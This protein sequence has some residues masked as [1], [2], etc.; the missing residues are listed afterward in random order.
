MK[1]KEKFRLSFILF[2]LFISYGAAS[3]KADECKNVKWQSKSCKAA[4]I[5][6]YPSLLFFEGFNQTFEFI[7]TSFNNG[8]PV[9]SGRI[10]REPQITKERFI[11]SEPFFT[12]NY[13]KGTRENAGYLLLAFTDPRKNDKSSSIELW[14]LN[15]Q[16]KIHAFEIDFNQIELKGKDL[17]RGLRHPLLLEDGSLITYTDTIIKNNEKPLLKINKCGKLLVKRDDAHY[18]HSI[19][20]DEDGLI[21]V[22]SRPKPEEIDLNIFPKGFISDGFHIFD[23]DLNLISK[24]S[25]IDIYRK[26]NLLK[27]IISHGPI[28]VD[29]FHLNDIQ[30]YKTINGKKIVLLSI[31]NQSQ[32]LAFDLDQEKIIWII[33]RATSHQHD[34]DIFSG[35]K[36]S[37]NISIFDNNVYFYDKYTIP[38]YESNR[39]ITFENL[40][41]NP[42][43]QIQFI[44]SAKK[45]KNYNMKIDSFNYLPNHLRPITK[46]E[47]LSE[48]SKNNNTLM[49]E[50][51]N[52]GRLF[53]VDLKTKKLLW[54]FINKSKKD[55]LSYYLNWSRRMDDLPGNLENNSFKSCGNS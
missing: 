29:P 43:K 55:G 18:H 50:E 37:I 19:E 10:V 9:I 40:N 34:V 42:N 8:Q 32:I 6:S 52:Y 31:R 14:D 1:L 15:Q 17:Q 36:D 39:Y 53:E 35:N 7:K 12:F 47:G 46:T 4:N 11:E 41:I 49:I 26:N 45:F 21:Y 13:K 38:E 30:P 51:T 54:K 3:F 5:I 2:F 48:F 16:E 23:S 28:K 27:D 33:D 20:I 24:Y 44:D 25:L 22:A